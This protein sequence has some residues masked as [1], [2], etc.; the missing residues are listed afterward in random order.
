MG[1]A[2]F[3]S[4]HHGEQAHLFATMRPRLVRLAYSWSQDA[5]LADDLAQEALTRALDKQGQLREMQAMP[6]WLMSILQN[7]WMDHLRRQ[8]PHEDLETLAELPHGGE[9][10]EEVACRGQ[11]VECV[12]RA[13]ARLPLGQRQVLT[14]VD[15]EEC[16]Y[17]EVAAI[18][19]IPIGTVM[20]RLSR[21]RQAVKA[22]LERMRAAKG[23][24]HLRRVV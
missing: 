22:D 24:G 3:F 13:V 4:R 14:L 6:A 7:C 1:I 9:G 12:R 18:L 11:V 23:G 10:P 20:S 2:K 5:H 16:G 8:H 21:A 17:A 15:L 19:G